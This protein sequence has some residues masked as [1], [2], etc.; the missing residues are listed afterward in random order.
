MGTGGPLPAGKSAAGA[1]R[2]PLTPIK[3]RGLEWVGAIPPLTPSASMACSGIALPFY[4]CP[5]RLWGPPSLLS[6]GYRGPFSGSKARPGR[7]SDHLPHLLPRSWMSRSYTSSP[8]CASVVCCGTFLFIAMRIASV[9][10]TICLKRRFCLEAFT[11][12]T[13]ALYY[14]LYLQDAVRKTNESNFL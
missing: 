4:P 8:P 12:C 14:S 13:L 7:D 11:N 10:T 3:C 1:W 9:M 5:D 6:N 2:W